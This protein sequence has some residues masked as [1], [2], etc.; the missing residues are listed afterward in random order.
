MIRKIGAGGGD[1]TA[2]R[3]AVERTTNTSRRDHT[4]STIV[5]QPWS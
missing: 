1:Q 2:A 4:A 3:F 5:P